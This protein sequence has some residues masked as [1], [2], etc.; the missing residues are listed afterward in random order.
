MQQVASS[1]DTDD[2]E[3]DEF[4][5]ERSHYTEKVL[6]SMHEDSFNESFDEFDLR[7]QQRVE[8]EGKT[9]F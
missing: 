8:V 6:T 2:K 3:N 4:L 7:G 9:L 5:P 1:S